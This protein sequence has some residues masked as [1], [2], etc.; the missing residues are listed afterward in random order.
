M[1][2]DLIDQ[3]Q[4]RARADLEFPDLGLVRVQEKFMSQRL[5]RGIADMVVFDI[6][7]DL[8]FPPHVLQ[9]GDCLSDRGP[10]V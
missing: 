9:V 7:L 5:Y 3:I 1:I 4:D 10:F 8:A 2:I 6:L